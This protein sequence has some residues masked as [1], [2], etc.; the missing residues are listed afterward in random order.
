MPKPNKRRN[1]DFPGTAR[2]PVLDVRIL[3]LGASTVQSR[4]Q[5]QSAMQ[6]RLKF[7]LSLGICLLDSIQDE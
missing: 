6:S 3:T 2:Q 7:A 5:V 1:A 4:G